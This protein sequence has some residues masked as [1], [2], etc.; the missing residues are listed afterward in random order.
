MVHTPAAARWSAIID[1]QE[2]SGQTLRAFA[3]ERGLNPS[4]LGWWRSRLGRTSRGKPL[5]APRFTEVEVAQSPPSQGAASTVVVAFE[6]FDAHVV[7]DRDTDLA[8]LREVLEAL[9]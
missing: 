8:L 1:E 9:C 3:A 2:A 4:T 6:H 5:Q 7:V